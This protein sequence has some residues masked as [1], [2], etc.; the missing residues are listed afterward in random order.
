MTKRMFLAFCLG[1]CAVSAVSADFGTS[2]SQ[3]IVTEGK[4][5]KKDYAAA[6]KNSRE[7]GRKLVVLIS[8]SWCGPCKQLKSD[9]TKAAAEG[10]LPKDC[11]IV[12]VEY[13]SEVGKKLSVSS[14]IPQLIRFEKKSDGKWYKNSNIGYLSPSKFK[15]FC[16]GE[17]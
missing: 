17:K 8:A 12:V 13:N 3:R 4:F 9:I 10:K 1:L 15:E 16:N 11:N 14:S 6:A 2:V 5:Y 7:T